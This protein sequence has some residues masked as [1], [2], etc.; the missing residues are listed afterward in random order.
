[1]SD[2]DT[3]E[4]GND[5][6]VKAPEFDPITSQEDLD[7][8]IQGRVSRVAAKYADYDDLKAKAAQF[9]QSVEEKKSEIQREREA[10]EAA[11]RERDELKTA[12]ERN[13]LR[14]KVSE[15]TGIPKALLTGDTEEEMRERADALLKWQSAGSRPPR[16]NPAQGNGSDKQP[17]GDWLRDAL[18][19]R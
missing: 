10:R 15:D 7:K 13:D 3:P 16:P 6:G 12:R 19:S 18:Q 1:M 14:E 9:D 11:E 8:I 2:N 5:E 17:A 4:G